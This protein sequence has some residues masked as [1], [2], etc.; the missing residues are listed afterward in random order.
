VAS[1]P[2]YSVTLVLGGLWGGLLLQLVM[3]FPSGRPH[4]R[5][6]PAGGG[7]DRR[8]YVVSE[9]VANVAKYEQAT[10]ASVAIRRADGRVTA[11]SPT[12]VRSRSC[13]WSPT[14]STMRVW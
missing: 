1:E 6:A 8:Y 10:E 3:A 13:G 4:A 2:L 7:R 14:I 5:G 11:E 12:T 9:A